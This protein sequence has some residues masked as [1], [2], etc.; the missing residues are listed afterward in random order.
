MINCAQAILFVFCPKQPTRDTFQVEKHHTALF[1]NWASL[2]VWSALHCSRSDLIN[3]DLDDQSRCKKR[4]NWS[5]DVWC[6]TQG[7]YH[8]FK[9]TVQGQSFSFFFPKGALSSSSS[10]SSNQCYLVIL[11]SVSW[12]GFVWTSY[13]FI[14]SLKLTQLSGLFQEHIHLD[15]VIIH[16][17]EE[18]CQKNFFCRAGVY[19]IYILWIHPSCLKGNFQYT[20]AGKKNGNM[21]C[22]ITFKVDFKL[23]RLLYH[24]SQ[25]E[26]AHENPRFRSG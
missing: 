12:N 25:N 8:K 4:E 10:L 24:F 16:C 23:K 13:T 1:Q 6:A 17:R 11:A 2:S 15:I 19:W 5:S 21:Q 18:G 9:I 22:I 3:Q 14:S 26:I 7:R 20:P